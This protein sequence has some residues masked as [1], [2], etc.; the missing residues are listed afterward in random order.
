[1][2]PSRK[3]GR[4]REGYRSTWEA[5]LL[6]GLAKTAAKYEIEPDTFFA[7]FREAHQFRESMCGRLLIRCRDK[8]KDA[9]VFLITN[10]YEVVTQFSMPQRFLN[11]ANPLKEFTPLDSQ[12]PVEDAR[13]IRDLRPGMKRVNLKVRVLEISEPKRVITRFG[14]SIYVANALVSDETGTVKLC[15]W[16]QQIN[17][18]S[19]GNVVQIENAYVTRFRGE[20][21]LRIRKREKINVVTRHR[22][23]ERELKKTQ[24]R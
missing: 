19:V 6:E 23:P 16:D 18:V 24:L 1:M 7:S 11:H 5:R 22:P 17:A 14:T 20:L 2:T 10:G 12:P 8:T 3:R 9:A 15:L 13:I 4:P 21:Q